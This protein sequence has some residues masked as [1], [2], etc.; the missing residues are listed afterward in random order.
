MKA[1]HRKELQTN[2]LADR[3]GKMLQGLKAGPKTTSIAI[4][5]VVLVVAALVITW[6]LV[7]KASKESRSA[8]WVKLDSANTLDDL[9]KIA[10]DNSGT[11]PSVIARFER[12]RYLL[13]SGQKKLYGDRDTALKELKQA[14]D[15]Y[16]KLADEGKDYPAL[17]QEALL[18]SATAREA[19]GDLAG[20]QPYYDKLVK[21]FGNT[22]LGKKAADEKEQE[23]ERQKFYNELADVAPKK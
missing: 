14:Q 23:K 9:K 16:D 13:Q 19:Q 3:L 2:L 22:F 17:V 12:A 10:D 1:E 11:V 20:A 4:W 15:L 7:S 6:I 18:G 5:V 21:S 8:L